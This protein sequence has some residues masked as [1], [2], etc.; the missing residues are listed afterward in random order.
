M[1]STKAVRLITNCAVLVLGIIGIAVFRANAIA[2]DADAVSKMCFA[3]STIAA[4][5]GIVATLKALFPTQRRTDVRTTVLAAMFA[6]LSYVG[7]AY[8]KIDIPVGTSSTA[9]HLG[10]V[11]VV[12]AALFLGGYWGGMAGA[13]GLTIA[14]LTTQYVTSAPKTFLLKLC[15]GLI[16][17]FI[18]HN[19][20]KLHEEGEKKVPVAV[21]ALVSCIAGM[22]F[23][24]VAD[25]IVGYFYK[26]YL[27]GVPQELAKVWA[28][29]GAVTTLVNAVIAVILATAFYLALRAPLARAGIFA[30]K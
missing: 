25:P 15:I 11:F 29:I 12:L 17:G 9:F 6:A 20:F 16:T 10:N 21:A 5:V 1:K 19:I 23:N 28:K 14:D 3:L 8:L 7:F 26:Q 4:V 24:V 30:K 18:A 2:A 27:L 13:V 22:G